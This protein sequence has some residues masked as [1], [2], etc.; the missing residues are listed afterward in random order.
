MNAHAFPYWLLAQVLENRWVVAEALVAPEFTRVH[1]HLDQVGPRLDRNLVKLLEDG[2]LDHLF[3][4]HL[5]GT[6]ELTHVEVTVPTPAG[7][8]FWREPLRLRL[9]VIQWPHRTDAAIAYIPALGIHILAATPEERKTKLVPEARAALARLQI[10]QKLESVVWVSRASR[11]RLQRREISVA[12]KSVKQ[13]ALALLDELQE[14]TSTLEQVATD[15]TT[16]W[17]DPLHGADTHLQTLAELLTGNRPRSV[18]LVGPSGAGKTAL[19]LNLA[20]RRAEFGLNGK[21]FWATSGARLVA[22][23]SGFGMW[24]ERCQKMLTEAAKKR[25]VVQVGNLMEL[26]DVGKCEG[27]DTGIAAFLRPFIARGELLTVAECTP[28]QIPLIEREDPHLLDAFTR[29]DVSEPDPALGRAILRFVAERT[30]TRR[31]TDEGLGVLDGLHRRYATYSAYPGRPLRFL[32]NFLADQHLRN[33]DEI[34]P[35]APTDIYAQFARE[36]G[37]PLFL[38][39][40]TEPVFLS[41]VRAWFGTRVLDQPEAVDLVTDLIALTK[42]A[43]NRPRRPIASLLFIGPTGVGKTEMA[44]A[45]AEYLFGSPGRLTRFDM[46]EYG[47]PL[48]VRRLI[49]GG[50]GREGLLTARIREQPFSVLL[51][52]EF[53]KAHPEFFDLLLQVL[54][55]GR[56]TDA[57]GRLADFCNC[58][59][60]LTSNLGAESYQRGAFGLAE[61]TASGASHSADRARSHF[62]DAV[63][64]SLRP[65]LFNRFD[66]IVPFNPLP[67]TAVARIAERHLTKLTTRDGVRY[68]GAS[69]TVAP[70]VAAQLANAGFDVRYGARPL[71]R[72][73]ERQLLAPLAEQM[74]RHP[75]EVPLALEVGTGTPLAV[76]VKPRTDAAGKPLQAAST[77][78]PVVEAATTLIDSR[79][80]AQALGRCAAMRELRNEVFQLEREEQWFQAAQRKY[81]ARMAALSLRADVTDEQRQRVAATAPKEKPADHTRRAR[82]AELRGLTDRATQL[83]T[84]CTQWEERLLVDLYSDPTGSA[85]LDMSAYTTAT[86][87]ALRQ[88]NDLLLALY[89]REY[90]Q[91]DALTVAVYSESREALLL[92]VDALVRAAK[93]SA[94]VSAKLWSFTLPATGRAKPPAAEEGESDEDTPV[95]TKQPSW[96]KDALIQPA[97]G[98]EPEAILLERTADD[99]R[100]LRSPP[101]RLIGILLRL[102]G[103]GV[104][105]KYLPEQGLHQLKGRDFVPPATC[106]LD[107][108]AVSAERYLPPTGI[109]RKGAIGTQP[110]RR[111]YDL[112]AEVAEDDSLGKKLPFDDAGLAGVIRTATEQHLER[113]LLSVLK[114]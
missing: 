85:N 53:E 32:R 19:V 4:R 51:F 86:E 10:T 73:I 74:N 57:A 43:L 114:E 26:V 35:L 106:W 14:T 58:V 34:K 78:Q 95:V 8:R 39:D 42:A 68:R 80:T 46:S 66:R 13:R 90:Q 87:Q 31:L 1:T 70:G 96:R 16:G 29:Y 9:P 44:K 111:V 105:L 55:E 109:T 110:R 107:A 2:P 45:L 99:G 20:Q 56:L 71:V 7:F 72:T 82:L 65:E 104:A 97:A 15:L 101:E 113:R 48:A 88:R 100:L 76:S 75:G 40:P 93:L 79:R 11:A 91:P 21:P 18:L 103:T 22:G 62:I 60:I 69:L 23:M 83:L 36:T 47:D 25:A 81:L 41:D 61:G 50:Q 30:S 59:I 63:Q 28:E 98:R 84:H 38:L 112:V 33:H 52:D 12:P 49:G 102:E 5:C 37:L 27:Q 67:P 64:R 6:P 94:G 54:G 17:C 3:R 92:L 77:A 89:R 108:D 24:Q